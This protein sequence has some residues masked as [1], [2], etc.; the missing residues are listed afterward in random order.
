MPAFPR[1]PSTPVFASLLLASGISVSALALWFQWTIALSPLPFP[2]PQQLFFLSETLHGNAAGVSYRSA[3]AWPR[4]QQQVQVSAFAPPQ[5]SAIESATGAHSLWVTAIDAN[6]FAVLGVRPI[7]GSGFA[8]LGEEQVILN[9][10]VW[11]THFAADPSV[12]GSSVRIG[13]VL[14]RCVG[15]MPELTDLPGIGWTGAWTMLPRWSETMLSSRARRMRALARHSLPPQHAQL[16]IDSVQSSLSREHPATHAGYGAVL[17][18]LDTFLFGSYRRVLALITAAAIGIALLA[19]A[20]SVGL[21]IAYAMGRTKDLAIRAAL[22]ATTSHII[23]GHVS[24][25]CI[26]GGFTAAL[27]LGLTMA[28]VRYVIACIPPGV[29]R[30][31]HAA[32]SWQAMALFAMAGIVA[33]GAVPL[34]AMEFARRHARSIASLRERGATGSIALRLAETWPARVQIGLSLTLLCAAAWM[35]TSVARLR[36]T[37]AGFTQER[38]WYFQVTLPAARYPNYETKSSFYRQMLEQL[39][40]IPNVELAAGTGGLP[41]SGAL[42]SWMFFVE[43]RQLPPPG[44]E[45]FVLT[46]YVSPGFFRAL[47]VPLIAG[48]AFDEVEGWQQPGKV[49]VNRALAQRFWP[50]ASAIGKRVKENRDGPWL[51]V[52]GVTGDVL[53]RNLR[54]PAGPELYHPYSVYRNFP[55]LGN[56]IQF[57]IRMREP[58]PLTGPQLRAL[59]S[60]LDPALTPPRLQPLQSLVEK[61]TASEVLIGMFLT[62]FLALAFCIAMF[63]VFL[64]VQA[65]IARRR[66]EFGIRA[67]LGAGS[68]ELLRELLRSHQRLLLPGVAIG[69][70]GALGGYFTLRGYFFELRGISWHI[71]VISTVCMIAAAVVVALPGFWSACRTDPASVLREE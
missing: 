58:Q 49:I 65:S 47:G 53:Q 28:G 56:R 41:L 51:E 24:M 17:T 40:K 14:L 67:A 12:I 35:L 11:R 52:I 8:G 25:A 69:L 38:G 54:E 55:M 62:L 21:W 13:G 32:L 50:E 70:A 39:Q 63:G 36:A 34:C 66:R 43:G 10:R 18:P 46:K 64:A 7:Q 19:L 27:T 59:M 31:E 71:A 33:G 5:E 57:V 29:P 45:E 16:A 26:C 61:Q 44:E 6:Y 15:V 9:E 48:R 20:N 4:E 68:R 42:G 37:S 1:R 22:G 30:M 2:G 23:R 60:R 3:S